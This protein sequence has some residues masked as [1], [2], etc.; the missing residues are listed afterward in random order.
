MRPRASQGQQCEDEQD[1]PGARPQRVFQGTHV[2]STA[3]AARRLDTG[4]VGLGLAIMRNAAAYHGGELVLENRPSGGLR[5]AL[6]LPRAQPITNQ[7]P[8]PAS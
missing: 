5:A 7:G 8:S 3:D 4:G 2:R 1:G 6:V